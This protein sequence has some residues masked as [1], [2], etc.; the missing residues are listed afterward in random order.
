MHSGCFKIRNFCSVVYYLC[1]QCYLVSG[2]NRR[3]TR[4]NGDFT[5]FFCSL[6]FCF[7]QNKIVNQSPASGICYLNFHPDI[8]CPIFRKRKF[9]LIWNRFVYGS[10]G[11][12]TAGLLS[13][14]KRNS[15][16]CSV[17]YIH[18]KLVCTCIKGYLLPQ[19]KYCICCRCIK[20]KFS[21]MSAFFGTQR[22][23]T[24]SPH[25]GIC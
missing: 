3:R 2:F 19:I 25:S 7:F 12:C 22:R 5:A 24:I 9:T 13:K 11:V 1:S 10:Y 15:S 20:I 4:G 8:N 17:F 21:V 16:I 6:L 18:A 14:Y 23:L